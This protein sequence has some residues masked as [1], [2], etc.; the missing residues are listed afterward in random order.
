MSKKSRKR[1]KKSFH[2]SKKRILAVLLV[3]IFAVGISLSI[4]VLSFELGSKHASEKLEKKE[5]EI[6]KLKKLQDLLESSQKEIA[7]YDLGISEID[8]L[9]ASQE[10]DKK[11]LETKK[12]SKEDHKTTSRKPRIAIILDDISFSSQVHRIKSLGLPITMSFLPAN[13]IH[14]NTP[15]MAENEEFYM[16]HLP[17]EAISHSHAEP[18]T[19]HVTDSAQRIDTTIAKIKKDFPRLMFLNNHTG[20][21]FTSDYRAMAHLYDS[22]DKYGLTFVDSRTTSK[23]QAPRLCKERAMNYIGRDVFLDHENS[24]EYVQGQ[25]REAIKIAKAT[26]LAIAI[27]H[28]RKE[29]LKAIESLKDE[30]SK[31]IELIYLNQI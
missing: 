20:S 28:P 21:L 15:K 25:I 13:A 24:V 7:E 18:N 9:R 31:D 8:D 26:G 30:L 4:G 14:P 10:H 27:G 6:S 29:T 23:T 2:L 19:L 16:V 17:L 11:V 12:K 1:A 22:L 5:I 3:A